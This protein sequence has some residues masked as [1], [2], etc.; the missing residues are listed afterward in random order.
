MLL[1]LLL[2]LQI[3]GRALEV[4][5]EGLQGTSVIGVVST[6]DANLEQLRRQRRHLRVDVVESTKADDRLQDLERK[7]EPLLTVA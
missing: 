6:F 7:M 4:P 5:D 3:G 2:L 1:L